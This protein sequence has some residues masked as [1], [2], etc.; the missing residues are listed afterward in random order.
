MSHENQRK[1]VN[2]I[3]SNLPGFFEKKKVLEIGS[4]DINGSVREF[5]SNC[6]YTGIDVDEG[7]SVDIVCEG[8]KYDAPDNSFDTVISCEVMEHN[9]YWAETFQNMIRVCKEGGLVVMTCATI[10]RPEH[11]TTRTSPHDS[12]L[13]VGIGWDYYKNL[14]QNHFIKNIDVENSFSN[15]YFKTNWDSYDLLFFGIKRA[16]NKDQ[17]HPKL[18]N[19]TTKIHQFV[20]SSNAFKR[21]VYRKYAAKIFGDRYFKGVRKL[22]WMLEYLH[23]D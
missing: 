6:N 16:K 5:F 8:Q 2:L 21:C 13:T 10:G 4:L 15:Y 23:N 14:T 20:E 19:L 7:K 22:I 3:A 11:G 17:H 12:P 18:E 1:Y 9:P